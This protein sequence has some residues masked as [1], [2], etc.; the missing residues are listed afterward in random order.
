MAEAIE[1]RLTWR[2][3]P[4]KLT[5]AIQKKKE[6]VLYRIGGWTRTRLRAIVRPAGMGYKPSGGH[7][8][9]YHVHPDAGLRDIEF[10]VSPS[11]DWVRI[12]PRI[13]GSGRTRTHRKDSRGRVR[14]YILEKSVP[15]LL[16]E[17]GSV[18]IITEYPKSGHIYTKTIRYRAFPWIT[19]TFEA[20]RVKFRQFIQETDL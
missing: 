2:G 19:P 16:D 9:R 4:E 17:G 18:I 3:R 5:Q 15:R 8:P 13:Y 1:L 7:P 6:N 10:N 11:N 12:R 14:K 20:A